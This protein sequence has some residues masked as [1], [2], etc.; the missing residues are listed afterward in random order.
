M[1]ESEPVIVTPDLPEPPDHLSKI[2]KEEWATVAPALFNCGIL[3]LIDRAALGAYCQAYGRWVMAETELAK[4]EFVRET[5]KGTLVQ[6]PLVGI[7]N[8]AAVDMV[9]F[10]GEFGMTPSSRTRLSVDKKTPSETAASK[11]LA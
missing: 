2:A 6:S 5:S 3:S 11:Y 4:V 9:R 1:N 7:A 8:K 10:A